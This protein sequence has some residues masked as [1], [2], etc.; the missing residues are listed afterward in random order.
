MASEKDT[1][2]FDVELALPVE[3]TVELLDDPD[4]V[5]DLSTST[6]VEIGK[7]SWSEA[8]DKHIF[9]QTPHPTYDNMP[10]LSIY[11]QNALSK[12]LS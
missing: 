4:F 11:F 1:Q 10:D 8:L 5:I 7:V 12:D 6:D 3:Y 9:N 2:R